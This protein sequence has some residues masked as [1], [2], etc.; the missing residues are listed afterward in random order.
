MVQVRAEAKDGSLSLGLHL[1][2]TDNMARQQKTVHKKSRGR[3]SGQR[4]SE[5]IPARLEPEAV[6]ALDK[7]AAD[8]NV[9]RSEAMRRLVEL[10]LKAKPKG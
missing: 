10:G 5:T 3:P 7:W 6:E 4:Y 8:H 9:S 2:Y 1:V